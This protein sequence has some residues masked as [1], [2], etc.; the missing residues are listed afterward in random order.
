MNII[1]NF[2]PIDDFI[3]I[4]EELES[5]SFP[6]YLG[7]VVYPHDLNT[8][9]INNFQMGHT[10]YTNYMPISNWFPVLYPLINKINPMSLVRIKSNITFRTEKIIEHGY[11]VDFENYNNLKTA[12]FYLNS[13]DGYTKFE[14][15]DIV[16]SLRNRLVIFDS[17]M[18][19]TGT[20]TTDDKYRMVINLN[21][22]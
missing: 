2:L 9:E 14:T 1:D 8:D 22:F 6:W 3:N 19:H 5:N 10:F 20:T 11:H 21:Y 13:N 4:K 7:N 16:E 18:R 17:N 12:V 15:G